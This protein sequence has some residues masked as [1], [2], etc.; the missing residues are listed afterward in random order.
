MADIFVSY[1][2][3]DRSR[4]V[5]FAQRLA[6]QGWSVWWDRTIPPGKS[7][8]EVIEAAI[9]DARCVVVLWSKASIASDGV[10]EE[11]EIGKRRNILIP[12]K[13]DPVEPPLEFRFIQVADLTDWH[14]QD[15]HVGFSS[16]L[17]D[18][19]SILGPSPQNLEKGEGKTRLTDEK[20]KTEAATKQRQI[21]EQKKQETAER[22]RLEQERR[23]AEE[24]AKAN[25][26]QPNRE[27][28]DR[29]K[30]TGGTK[31]EPESVGKDEKPKEPS[32]TKPQPPHHEEHTPTHL[33][34]PTRIDQLNRRPFADVMAIRIREI[35]DLD[36]QAGSLPT[37]ARVKTEPMSS[38]GSNRKKGELS[39]A[40]SNDHRS[41]AVHIHGPWGAG[42]TSVLNFLRK[43]LEAGTHG[44]PWV[45]VD[46]N[47]WRHQRTRPPWWTLIHQVYQQTKS[48]LQHERPD[49]AKT[50]RRRWFVWR[51]RADW[52][53][54]VM[55]ALV[56]L[57]LTL[58]VSGMLFGWGG[59]EAVPQGT[60]N[61]AGKHI[62]TGLK[63]LTAL[64]A[65]GAGAIALGRSLLFGSAKAAQSYLEFSQDPMG[66]IAQLFQKLINAI[67]RPVA[68]FIDDLDRC[69]SD[70]VV[71]L[72]EGIQTLFRRAD[73][74]YVVAADRD[75]IR[76]S[77]EKHYGDFTELITQP[78]R[79]LGYLFLEKI[80][81]VSASL[82]LLSPSLRDN[83]W[84]AL[85]KATA[86]GKSTDTET[87]ARDA[88]RE[89]EKLISVNMTPSE[90]E[91][92][93][94][95]HG[96]DPIKQHGLRAVAAKRI[97]SRKSEKSRA[98]FLQPF[99]GLLEPNPRAMK[100]LINAYGIQQA[101]NFLEGRRVDP[102]ALALWT[103]IEMRWPLLANLL[104]KYPA[105]ISE[106]GQETKPTDERIPD[107]LKDLFI[108][109]EIE[110]VVQGN[111]ISPPVALD[112]Q[113]IQQAVGLAVLEEPVKT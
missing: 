112:A 32:Q 60:T 25:A 72:L 23:R 77:Y 55:A 57:F 73:V 43:N 107:D 79:P 67:G 63:L 38:T 36:R 1:A 7:F 97:S 34:D 52:L 94:K 75:W 2:S 16:L 61:G 70:Y 51:L 31:T 41:L 69:D 110:R 86:T 91:N 102:R 53:P 19:A 3:Q 92:V 108:S 5:P 26:R 68:I 83:Y 54:V 88:E 30:F 24:E 113:L 6:A 80:F 65:A 17:G 62:E 15:D 66:P 40:P 85:L 109:P 37:E 84:K 35:W 33:D 9:T 93:I 104:T 89:A 105:L 82:P 96:K 101:V 27:R 74:T 11:A 59:A 12:A 22:Q 111:G 50:L 106:F 103:I 21:D 87:V 44:Q 90:M 42:K 49:I 58:F 48:R 39:S 18:V 56:I 10:Q 78:A 71:E 47:A 8:D 29:L 100:R 45:V 64:L 4:V 13:I 99:A 20:R 95:D 14:G 46:F 28:R 98:H 81:Q 76:A